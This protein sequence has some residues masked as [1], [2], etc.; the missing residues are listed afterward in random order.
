MHHAIETALKDSDAAFWTQH[1]ESYASII[2]NC[3]A[4]K[5]PCHDLEAPQWSIEAA[6]LDGGTCSHMSGR[7]ASGVDPKTAALQL[8]ARH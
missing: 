2:A 8:D 7:D 4:S 6:F 5:G 1:A 3:T